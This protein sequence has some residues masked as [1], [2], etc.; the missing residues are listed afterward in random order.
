MNSA[1]LH[2]PAR[3]SAALVLALLTPLF[4]AFRVPVS[5]QTSPSSAEK[6]Q[7]RIARLLSQLES[8][9]TFRQV[10]LSPDGRQI[11]W[12]VDAPSGHSRVELAE[13]SAPSVVRQISAVSAPDSCNE[14]QIA[15]SPDGQQL[16][17]LS[18]CDSPGQSQIFLAGAKAGHAPRK[19]GNLQGV[20]DS[21][22]WSPNGKSSWL[23]LCRERHPLCR[24]SGR[25][26]AAFRSN[27][28]R[29][30]RDP[31]CGGGGRLRQRRPAYDFAAK[32]SRLRI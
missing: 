11:A 5:A 31:A 21:L 18:D 14:G 30:S 25:H 8:V 24:R 29:R 22:Q 26:E 13:V 3:R 19:L 15:W 20:V 9:R 10:A 17:F 6:P 28:R 23:P 12:V 2:L 7:A 4:L 16:A 1:N 27:W 32:S